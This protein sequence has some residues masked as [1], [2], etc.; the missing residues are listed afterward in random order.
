M[1]GDGFP[2]FI[3]YLQSPEDAL[4]VTRRQL[5]RPL[6]VDPLQLPVQGVGPLP[7]GPFLQLGAYLPG[8]RGE[9]PAGDKGVDIQPGAAHHDGQ[10]SPAADIL[11]AGCRLGGVSGHAVAFR[12]VGHVQHVMGHALLLLLGGLGGADAHSAVQLHGVG[13]NHLAVQAQRQLNPQAGFSRG[14]G[15]AE[16][17]KTGL[18]HGLHRLSY[19]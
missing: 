16:Y 7:G 13:G 19:K 12:R 14:G 9:G 17:Q 2:R 11:D 1:A 8:K 3:P 15:A 4:P 6:R 5:C 18:G 10:L